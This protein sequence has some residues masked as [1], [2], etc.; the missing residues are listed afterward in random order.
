[1]GNLHRAEDEKERETHDIQYLNG[2]KRVAGESYRP[3]MKR[4]RDCAV[5]P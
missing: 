5:A 3:H 2:K 1:M 4:D